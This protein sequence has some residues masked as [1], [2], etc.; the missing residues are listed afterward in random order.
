MIWPRKFYLIL[1]FL[2][3]RT[4]PRFWQRI[5]NYAVSSIIFFT[6]GR[7]RNVLKKN[8]SIILN[9]P[10]DDPLVN[11]TARHTF[12]NYGLYLIDYTRLNHLKGHLLPEQVGAHYMQEAMDKGNGAILVTSHLGNWELG[13]VTFAMRGHPIH[14]LTLVDPETHVQDFRDRMRSTLGIHTVH[15][16]PNNY[17]TVLKLSRLL[18]E[19]QVIAMLGDRYEGGKNVEVTFF[20]KRVMFPAGAAALALATGAPIIPAFTVLKPNGHYLAWMEPPIYV[21]RSSGKTAPQLLVEKTQELAFVFEKAASQYPDQWYHF[22][23]Y[24]NYYAAKN[25]PA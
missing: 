1:L 4:T 19:N 10:I 7:M 5:Q 25:S 20:S 14:A 9:R 13:G 23:D 12:I 24:W 15:I 18:R 17:T 21:K 11:K 6:W 3:S 2:F 8:I 16:D 22:F